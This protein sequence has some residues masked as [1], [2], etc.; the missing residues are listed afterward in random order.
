MKKE[1]LWVSLKEEED[2]KEKWMRRKKM[3]KKEGLPIRKDKVEGAVIDGFGER[4]IGKVDEK[5]EKGKRGVVGR[6]GGGR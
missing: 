5:K 3:R 6:H 1:S 2:E 4:G